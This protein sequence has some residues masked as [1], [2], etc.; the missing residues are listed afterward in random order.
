[1]SIITRPRMATRSISMP[2]S[3]PNAARADLGRVTLSDRRNS[4]RGPAQ[5]RARLTIMDGPGAGA[6]HNVLTREQP[7]VGVSFMLHAELTVG[8]QCELAFDGRPQK[9]QGEVVRCR[10]ISGG[11]YEAAVQIRM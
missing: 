8:Q 10:P 3:T 1:M 7:L 9:V 6:T 4:L 5:S 11:R 2:T